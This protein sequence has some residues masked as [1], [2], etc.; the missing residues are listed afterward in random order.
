[1]FGG[2]GGGGGTGAAVTGAV[3][4]RVLCVVGCEKTRED[5]FWRGVLI[6]RYC[7]LG[8]NRSGRKRAGDVIGRLLFDT[9][10]REK[11]GMGRAVFDLT[12]VT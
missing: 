10:L 2:L 1:M 6:F 12:S 7:A 4:R 9:P 11:G 8:K 5:R 3:F